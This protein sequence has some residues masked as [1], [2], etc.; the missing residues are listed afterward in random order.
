LSRKALLPAVLA[1]SNRYDVIFGQWSAY[2]IAVEKL[3]ELLHLDIEKYK[4]Q[5]EES[6]V[7]AGDQLKLSEMDRNVPLCRLLAGLESDIRE[8]NLEEA[9]LVME[10]LTPFFT[11][12][13]VAIVDLGWHSTIQVYL[14][15]IFEEAQKSKHLK[16][17]YLGTN[18]PRKSFPIIEEGYLFDTSFPEYNFKT[19]SFLMECFCLEL[20]GT[21]LEY[22]KSN[23][24]IKP[25]LDQCDQDDLIYMQRIQDGCLKFI[26]DFLKPGLWQFVS[27]SAEV[28]CKAYQ[29]LLNCPSKIECQ[30]MKKVT[31]YD[32]KKYN[33]V[34]EINRKHYLRH[35]GSWLQDLLSAR[36][37]AAFLKETF[38][39]S[40]R[41]NDLY[42][43]IVGAVKKSDI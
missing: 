18:G 39:L 5:L 42:Y 12:E 37:K 9:A 17:F 23:G 34:L 26:R 13:N 1:V 40:L 11:E 32:H 33:L 24:E 3:F 7:H 15:L 31:I 4:D 8:A 36:W 43:G 16:G 30:Q 2:G 14:Q 25:V 22:K 21:V 28:I 19:G 35:P 41:W 29:N 10:Y 38:R 6:G 20:T 27:I